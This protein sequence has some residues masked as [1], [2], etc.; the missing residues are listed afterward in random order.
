M[1]T[2]T[3]IKNIINGISTALFIN[4]TIWL[5][6]LE[7]EKAYYIRTYIASLA[8]GVVA[9]LSSSIFAIETWSLAKKTILHYLLIGGIVTSAGVW[10]GWLQDVKYAGGFLFLF[11]AIYLIIYLCAFFLQRNEIEKINRELKK[12]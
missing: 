4:S 8:I 9:G 11:S 3:H 12:R 1:K 7:I 2:I 5:A 10:A 6:H